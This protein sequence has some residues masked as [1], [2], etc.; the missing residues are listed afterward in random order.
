M[1][2]QP[3]QFDSSAVAARLGHL[4]V[5]QLHETLYKNSVPIESGSV[6]NY[7]NEFLPPQYRVHVN[8][9]SADGEHL[10]GTDVT[11]LDTHIRTVIE[12]TEVD[13]RGRRVRAYTQDDCT[14]L[15]LVIDGVDEMFVNRLAPGRTIGLDA[16]VV[17]GRKAFY[18]RDLVR[19][20]AHQVGADTWMVEGV[21]VKHPERVLD[22]LLSREY[23]HWKLGPVH[24]DLHSGNVLFGGGNFGVI[25][26]GKMR[27]RF[28]VLYDIAFLTSHANSKRVG[29]NIEA[30]YAKALG[31]PILALH[32]AG[33]RPNMTTDLADHE[34]A[35]HEVGELSAVVNSLLKQ[36]SMEGAPSSQY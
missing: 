1:L 32:L 6:R 28:P 3:S 10:V 14:K 2:L 36:V 31:K 9:L 4:I 24:G 21:P 20:G 16:Q 22:A 11:G 8:R 27:E 13:L 25:D 5:S 34:M 23:L 19:L 17:G 33:D 35:Y 18:D 30:G 7:L 26:Y 29:L 12:V 15:D